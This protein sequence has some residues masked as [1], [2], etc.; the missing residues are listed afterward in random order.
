MT[1]DPMRPL[2]SQP[3]EAH[4]QVFLSHSSADRPIIDWVAA[5]IE[6]MGIDAYRADQDVQ[7]GTML[8]EKIRD[9]IIRSDALLALLTPQ[10]HSSRYVPKR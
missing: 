9:A 2:M 10:G 6:A 3:A 1:T 7:T 4:A 8:A 5:Q